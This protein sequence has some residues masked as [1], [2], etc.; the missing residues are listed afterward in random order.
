MKL[1]RRR[2]L[3]CAAMTL[4]TAWQVSACREE[5][6]FFGLRTAFTAVTLPINQLIQQLLLGI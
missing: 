1:Y 6:A 3:L 5:F 2:W 4:G